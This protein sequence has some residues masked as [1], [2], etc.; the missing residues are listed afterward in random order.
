MK[1]KN[2]IYKIFCLYLPGI[3]MV[4]L[5]VFPDISLKTYFAI[6]RDLIFHPYMH[7][8]GY[9]T[10]A[11]ICI[12]YFLILIILKY[13]ELIYSIQTVKELLLFYIFYGMIGFIQLFFG[14][15]SL[16]TLLYDVKALLYIFV[17]YLI[18]KIY[19]F[20]WSQRLVKFIIPILFIGLI[21]DSVYTNLF[22]GTEYAEFL[23]IPGF[24]ES[25]LFGLVLSYAFYF[26]SIITFSALFIEIIGTVNRLSLGSIYIILI[27]IIM[28]LTFSKFKKIK[29][30]YLYLL[31]FLM[32]FLVIVP[33]I[34]SLNFFGILNVKA[35]SLS[36]RKQQFYEFIDNSN[37]FP[38]VILGNGLGALWDYK[39]SSIANDTYSVGNSMSINSNLM[40]S[41]INTKRFIFNFGPAAIFYKFGIIGVCIMILIISKLVY[42][43]NYIYRDK[44][45]LLFQFLVT[46]FG[47]FTLL[48]IGTLKHGLLFGIFLYAFEYT[49]SNAPLFKNKQV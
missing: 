16:K 37:R 25:S 30:I 28:I 18:L 33:I 17:P 8:I 26:P 21:S 34:I 32:I 44:K 49:K 9:F 40:E 5:L 11:D 36:I 42:L 10:I 35:D 13:K 38:T 39:S 27:S 47:I 46:Y 48:T 1:Y 31:S 15:S 4:Y 24:I 22:W 23:H 6:S 14:Y 7:R 41:K 3:L 20:G 29:S 12:F 2:L 19:K 45:I 43:P